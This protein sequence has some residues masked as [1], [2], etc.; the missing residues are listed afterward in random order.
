[1]TTTAY[2]RCPRCPR[3]PHSWHGL[4]CPM[5]TCSCPSAWSPTTTQTDDHRQESA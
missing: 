5:S 1:M 3:C 4:P 2:P